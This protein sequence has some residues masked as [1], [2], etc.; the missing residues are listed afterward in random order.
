M[1]LTA[2]LALPAL[3]VAQSYPVKPVRIIVPAAPGGGLDV[4]ARIFSARL[5]DTWGQQA[6]VEN[7]AGANFIVGTETVAK[8]A[9]DGYTLLYTS[10][11]AL[12]INPVTYARLP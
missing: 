9:P 4:T 6:V 1:A 8:S 5:S 2:F 7:R 11:A 12:T 10:H 3:S